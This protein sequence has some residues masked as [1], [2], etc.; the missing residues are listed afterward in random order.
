MIFPL[1]LKLLRVTDDFGHG[2]FGASRGYSKTHKG[3]DYLATKD[4]IVKSPFNGKITK[5]GYAYNGDLEQRY[6]EISNTDNK[7]VL[8]IFYV[9]MLS[10]LNIGDN[11]LIGDH[12]ANVGDIS[13]K[14]STDIK[15]MENH[16]HLEIRKNGELINPEIFFL[17][18]QKK[19]IPLIVWILLPSFILA[20]IY[21]SK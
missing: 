9:N 12:I 3:T 10:I 20:L 19:S 1:F 6:I 15:K 7:H 5:Y 8:R 21:L 2:H 4:D 13:K 14:Y 18:N 16:I 11:V 17:L